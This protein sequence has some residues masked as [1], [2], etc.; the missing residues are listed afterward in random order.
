MNKVLYTGGLYEYHKHGIKLPGIWLKQ[1]T[2]PEGMTRITVILLNGKV[3]LDCHTLPSY[4][5]PCVAMEMLNTLDDLLRL[6]LTNRS[7]LT[8]T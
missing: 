7:S 6:Y 1:L 2:M 5:M 4:C 8:T 3:V